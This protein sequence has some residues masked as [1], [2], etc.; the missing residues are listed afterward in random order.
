[1]IFNFPLLLVLVLA[2]IPGQ[3][4]VLSG[5]PSV[6]SEAPSAHLEVVSTSLHDLIGSGSSTSHLSEGNVSSELGSSFVLS[7]HDVVFVLGD[8]HGSGS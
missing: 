3:D 2:V 7:T 8:S 6:R 4:S 1:V 5:G